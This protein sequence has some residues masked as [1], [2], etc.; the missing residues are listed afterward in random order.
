MTD[1]ERAREK[2]QKLAA[3][4]FGVTLDHIIEAPR[5]CGDGYDGACSRADCEIVG[6]VPIIATAILEAGKKGM[7]KAAGIADNVPCE[8]VEKKRLAASIAQAIRQLKED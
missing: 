3:E 4:I 7:E 8:T 5:H 6:A 2:A 1:Q